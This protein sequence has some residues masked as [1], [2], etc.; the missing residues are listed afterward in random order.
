[1]IN[2]YYY[3]KLDLENELT[4]GWSAC[5]SWLSKVSKTCSSFSK[6]VI[7]CDRFAAAISRSLWPCFSLIAAFL[8][9]SSSDGGSSCGGWIHGSCH[10]RFFSS[11][12]FVSFYKVESIL[13]NQNAK[14]SILHRSFQTP[15][16]GAIL[17]IYFAIV[18]HMLV[19]LLA[20]KIKIIIYTPEKAHLFQQ[21]P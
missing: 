11:D 13:H 7:F 21:N 10:T 8:A 16:T 14:K 4:S 3:S 20:C 12:S 19:M 1:M 15:I 5:S 6:S 18:K 9:S 2:C 17:D